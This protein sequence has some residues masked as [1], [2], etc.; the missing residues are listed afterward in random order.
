MK[1]LLS[2]VSTLLAVAAAPAPG[3]TEPAFDG[4]VKVGVLTDQ[5]SLYADVT[6]QGSVVAARMALED[7]MKANPNSKLKV[8]IIFAD[9]QNKPDIGANLARQWYDRDGVDM[10]LDVPNSAV[11]LAVS[12]VTKQANKVHVNG[13]A[14][15]ARL[16]GDACSPNTVHWTF[17]N[18]ALANGTG[19]A[20]VQTGGDTW[21]FI[22]ADYAFGHDLEAQTSAVVKAGGGKIIGSVRAPLNTPDFSSFLLQAQSSKAHV[23]GL[24]NAGGD[25]INSIKQAAEFGIVS[26][27]QRLAGLLVFV[28]DVHALGLQTAQGLQ[29]TEA[30][31]WDMNDDTRAWTKRFV[32]KMNGKQYPTMNHAGT[33]GG[34]LHFLKAIEAAQTRDGAKIVAKMKELPTDDVTFGKGSV[35]EDGRHIHPMY[36]WEVKKP[37]ESKAAWDYYKLVKTIPADQA[38]RP[39]DQ[40]GCPFVKK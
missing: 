4:T 39:L 32:E 34:M 24:A 28:T 27:G 33:Y 29:F 35:R 38:W 9:H 12:E 23:I 6:G 17:D 11:A 3:Q 10:I 19:R 40:G 13:S 2:I 37:S 8:E 15:T 14:G 20:I 16:T 7:Y 30:F 22:T 5:S 31:Y 1:R 26:A 21:F 18:F 36:L 25:T